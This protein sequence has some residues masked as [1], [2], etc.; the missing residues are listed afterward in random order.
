MNGVE[1]DEMLDAEG[2][3]NTNRGNIVTARVVSATGRNCDCM[4]QI[5]LQARPSVLRRVLY[6]PSELRAGW[7]LLVFVGMVA[8][9]IISTNW[10]VG[11]LLPRADSTTLFLVFEVINFLIFL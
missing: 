11:R 6:G 3:E 5:E 2:T 10:I 7:R 8:A 4:S 1:L 9:M